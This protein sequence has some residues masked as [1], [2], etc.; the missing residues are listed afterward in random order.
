MFFNKP[1]PEYLEVTYLLCKIVPLDAS[2]QTTL[3]IESEVV[4]KIVTSTTVQNCEEDRAVDMLLKDN[5]L[6]SL[7]DC[8][9][10]L[11]L[12]VSY[13]NFPAS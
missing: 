12:R 3:T 1:A 5:T 10:V 7:K 2:N 11:Q 8:G 9:S 13:S 4:S 6:A